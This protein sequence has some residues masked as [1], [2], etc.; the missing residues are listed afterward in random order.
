MKRLVILLCVLFAAQFVCAESLKEH[1]KPTAYNGWRLG[2]QCWSFNRFTMFEAIDKTRSLGLNYVQGYPGQKVAKDMDVQF[3]PNLNAEQ[4][5]KVKAKLAD[6]N[7]EILAFGVT[8]IPGNEAEARKLFEFAKDMGIKTIASEPGFDQF[9]MIDNLCQEYEIKLAIHNHPKPSTYWNPDTVLKMC[10]G[11]SKWIG[12]CTDVG[13]WVRSGLDPVECLKILQGRIH[14]VHAKEI[15]DG[16]DVP[17]G[18]AQGRMKGILTELHRQNYRGTFTV[19]YEHEWDNNVP[20]IR[21]C[22]DFFDT[23][24]SSLKPSGWHELFADDLFNADFNAGSWKMVDNVLERTGSGDVWTKDKFSDYILDFD[25]KLA[26]Q[27]NSGVFL[28]AAEHTWLPWPEIQV[29][30]SFGKAPNRHLCGGIYDISAPKVNSVKK[31]GEWN[32]MTIMADGSD[33]SVVLNG[34]LVTDIDLDDWTTAGKN[35]DGSDNKFKNIAY[36]DLPRTG[37]IGFQ[38]HG[39]VV[40]YRNIKVKDLA[41]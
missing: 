39:F 38:D 37:W 11:R 19:E 26:E 30:D 28:R 23:F 22:V 6:A 8:G 31:P 15:E 4:R 18:T 17:W 20:S 10:E 40:W 2:V 32:H 12:A 5:A 1:S 29:E 34:Q 41:K 27:T 21:K 14:D 9:D 16:H 36:K 25:F 33:I 3:G 24:A 13:H 7:V 35:P